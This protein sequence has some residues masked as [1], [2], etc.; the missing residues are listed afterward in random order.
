MLLSIVVAPTLAGSVLAE[1]S[2]PETSQVNFNIPIQS[3]PA[4]L[5]DLARQAKVPLFFLS[6]GFEDVQANAV[7]GTYS[8][9]QA[10][11][12]LLAGTGLAA[13][14]SSESGVK[15]KPAFTSIEPLY[16]AAPA[17]T[18]G[19]IVIK[20]EYSSEQLR[21]DS[22]KRKRGERNVDHGDY[23]EMEEIVVT[24]TSIRGIIPES[25]PLKVYDAVD[26]RNTGALTIEQFVS[27]L[28][29]NNNTLS[30][31]G[32][33]A[34]AQEVN[35][36]AV[37]AVDLRGLGVGSTLVL[38]NGRRMAPSSS[39]RSADVSFIPIA[40]VERVE[41]LTDGASAIYGAD[42]IGGVINFVLKDEQDGAQS[43]LTFGAADG[44]NEHVRFD[45]SF[46]LDWSSGDA[47]IV[48]SYMDRNSLDA[49]DRHFSQSA[50]PFTLIPSDT[51]KNILLTV[52]QLLP[53]NLTVA[54][55]LL[56]ST[57]RPHS[58]TG[59]NQFPGENF[60]ESTTDH[61]QTIAN[62]TVER[63][64]GEDLHAA[65]FLT[66]ADAVSD[67]EGT[68]NGSVVGHGPFFTNHQS[69]TFDVTAKVDG[70]LVT[71]QSGAVKFALGIGY[72]EDEYSKLRDFSVPTGAAPSVAA[73]DRHS[74]YAFAE[75]HAPVV[76]PNQEVPGIRRLELNLAARY[77]NYSDF[78]NDISPKV[79]V[80][81]APVAPLRIRG[82]LGESFKAPFLFQTD[83]NGGVNALAPVSALGTPDIWSP[84]RS[85]IILFAGGPGNPNLGPERAETST[86]G[87]DVDLSNLTLSATLF[88]ITYEDRIAEPD[89]QGGSIALGNPQAF[90]DFFNTDP[91]LEEITAL[92]GATENF[93]NLTAVNINDPAAVHAATTVLLDNRIRNLFVSRME[94]LDFSVDYTAEVFTG[95]F[96]VGVNATKLFEFEEQTG[97]NAAPVTKVDTVLFPADLDARGY[98]GFQKE[99]WNARLNINYVDEYK[100]PFSTANST[101]AAWTTLDLLLSYAFPTNE[102]G[103]LND[104]RLTLTIQNAL[105][106][107]PPFLPVGATSDISIINP[108]GFDPANA[109]PL[110]R[111]INLQISKRW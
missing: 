102:A 88:R 37:N 63:P 75:L 7:V 106:E 51:R 40:A 45:Q 110:G 2:R 81:W 43:V 32:S 85:S 21:A 98:V 97:V 90:P 57:R 71:F 49:A 58:A 79:G 29:Q 84:D 93:L 41:I 48:L 42:A 92:L 10:L 50:V 18:A 31:I 70:E 107:D 35:S 99:R 64:I 103:I 82:T 6:D 3:V 55:D 73:L 20:D 89:S 25:T 19:A 87:F 111:Y 52:E 8:T 74:K 91:T 27:R 36:D 1:E 68:R 14:Y 76:S 12:L 66:Y 4:A 94:G 65:L 109:N 59:L 62:L 100:N 95:T 78:G 9:Q 105:D 83:P 33:G 56:Y 23:E 24:G 72:L 104:V 16:L 80:L 96:S 39:G 54:T 5:S 61:K 108:V 60:S 11:D 34:S 44:G 28:P 46:G 15:V 47:F 69:S 26:I 13:S 77:T 53:G 101:V 86:F 30:E 38:L 22:E 17:A 67:S